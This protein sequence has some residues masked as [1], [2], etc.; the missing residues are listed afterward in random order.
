MKSLLLPLFLLSACSGLRE[1]GPSVA[2]PLPDKSPSQI[3]AESAPGDW[4]QL[5]PDYTLYIDIPQGRIVVALSKDL[6]VGHVTQIRALA[7][8]GFYD[9]LDFYRVIEG[10]VA[11]GGDAK[12]A[13]SV[14]SASES[15]D[16]E[17]DEPWS[18]DIP[19]TPLGNSDGY[20]EI[21]GFI[22]GFPAGR[23]TLDGRVW[24][25]HCSGAMAFARGGSRNSASTEFYLTL[26]PQR[27][28]DRNLTVVGAV[29]WGM[30]HV[31]SI[32][33]GRP[34]NGGTIEDESRWTKINSMNVASDLPVEDRLPIEIFDTNTSAFQELMEA[35]R[36]RPEDFF[37][38]RPNH[39]DL[40]Q[41][42]VPVRL[43]Q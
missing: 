3:V 25:A 40:C 39:L 2:V 43:F 19:F 11:Q 41:M 15:V 30:E 34:G 12:N 33:R 27:Y 7:R 42:P 9:G 18:R 13:K 35:R 38:Y 36:N 22:N 37:F 4:I 6:A 31:Q 1:T 29:V 32:S 23:S 10:F 14:Q 8:E 26:Q 24:L 16:A 21:A 28:L 17:F 5:D 20:A